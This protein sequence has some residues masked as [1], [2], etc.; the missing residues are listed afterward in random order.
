MGSTQNI[1]RRLQKGTE[2]LTGKLGGYETWHLPALPGKGV[3]MISYARLPPMTKVLACLV[4][5]SLFRTLPGSALQPVLSSRPNQ[6]FLSSSSGERQTM[7]E[8][9]IGRASKYN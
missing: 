6:Y 7:T 5:G 2:H 9:C 3:V 4:S 1:K 8:N